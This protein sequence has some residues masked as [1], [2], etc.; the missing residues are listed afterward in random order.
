MNIVEYNINSIVVAN[1]VLRIKYL[2]R[3]KMRFRVITLYS[4]SVLL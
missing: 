2:F 3:I 1:L 4:H